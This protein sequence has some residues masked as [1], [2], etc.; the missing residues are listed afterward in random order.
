MHIR[1]MTREDLPQVT[2]ITFQTFKDDEMYS[3]LQPNMSKYP[4][5][6]R[7][8]MMIRLRARL[9]GVGQSGLVA[10]TDEGDTNW[11]GQSEIAGYAYYVRL[12]DDEGAKRWKTDTLYKS[13]SSVLTGCSRLLRLCP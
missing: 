12:G 2:E 7:R 8:T 9:V 10:V 5:D 13:T 1:P 3:Y 4:D 6:A 11:N